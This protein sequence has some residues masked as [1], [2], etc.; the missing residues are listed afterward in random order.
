MEERLAY[1]LANAGIPAFSV[2]NATDAASAKIV[3]RDDATPQHKT[4]AAA[5]VAS[6]D[7]SQAAQDAF[8]NKR[9]RDQAV[10]SID[11]QQL[12]VDPILLATVLCI[13]DRLQLLGQTQIT[14][15][16]VLA[17]LKSNVNALVS[18]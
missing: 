16:E 17:K 14:K 9:L 11:L 13:N 15:A 6:F 18:K 5:I 10:A 1:V 4:Q 2:S 7:F 8:E 12:K 3:F